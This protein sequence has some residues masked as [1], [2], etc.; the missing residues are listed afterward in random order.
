MLPLPGE[1]EVFAL[2]GGVPLKYQLAPSADRSTGDRGIVHV[3]MMAAAEGE[4]EE[5]EEEGLVVVVRPFGEVLLFVD[6][7]G[8]GDGGG[9]GGGENG[10]EGGG[11]I[12]GGGTTAAGTREEACCCCGDVL[13]PVSALSISD[14]I[15]LN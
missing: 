4:R 8:G 15:R 3:G 14:F 1:G 12:A 10:G 2:D 11:A 13:P 9:D 6:G 5:R 7:V